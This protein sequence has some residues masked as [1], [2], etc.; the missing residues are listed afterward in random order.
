MTTT[1]IQP[2][3]N[4]LLHLVDTK[5]YTSS[6]VV[7]IEGLKRSGKSLLLASMLVRDMTIYRRSVWSTMPVKTPEGLLKKGAPMVKSIPINWDTLYMLDQ[8][9]EEGTIG[10]D[11]SI[12]YDDSRTSLSM[13]NKLLNTIMNQ[14]GH[15]SLNV[16]YTVK[17]QGWLD[18]RLQLETDIRIRCTDLAKTPWGR[19]KGLI[20]G[21]VIKLDFFDLSGFFST[22]VFNEKF[23]PYPFFSMLWNDA[24]DYWTAYNTKEIIGI[25]DLMTR[26][27]VDLKQRVIS[28]KSSVNNEIK[29][30]L[31][32]LADQFRA[33]S[34]TIDCDVYWRA[35][36][37]MGIP[38][39]SRQLG[40]YL[41]ELNITHKQKR[42]GNVYEL[43]QLLAKE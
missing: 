17:S 37:A 41:K 20:Q 25:E 40:Q 36:D 18:R 43:S 33:K 30:A 12:Y 4:P 2:N 5:A 29:E 27:K 31:Y 34:D 42:G 35:A 10:L 13:R 3:N 26:V 24:R 7:A 22:R 6:C 1:L 9:Y 14:V 32:D 19:K 16:Y 8:E 23:N 39:G 21:S 28:N 11:E 15:R 38:G